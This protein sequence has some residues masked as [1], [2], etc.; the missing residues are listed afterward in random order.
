MAT[1]QDLCFIREGAAVRTFPRERFSSEL[2]LTPAMVSA[3]AEGAGD[4]NPVHSRRRVRGYDAIW[5]AD[6][7]GTHTT[8]LLL[9]LTIVLLEESGHGWS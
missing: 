7:S 9:G 5:P 8:A 1:G 6:R 3:Y 4:T 2:T